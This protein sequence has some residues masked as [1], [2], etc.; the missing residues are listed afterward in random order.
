MYFSICSF[1]RTSI[2]T[3]SS[4][5]EIGIFIIIEIRDFEIVIGL[6]NPKEREEILYSE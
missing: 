2:C 5:S 3:Q 6:K 1:I 4:G